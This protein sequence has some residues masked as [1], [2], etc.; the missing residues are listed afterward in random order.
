V[1]GER[2]CQRAI[3]LQEAKAKEVWHLA[4]GKGTF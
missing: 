2:M 1:C 3:L 4:V